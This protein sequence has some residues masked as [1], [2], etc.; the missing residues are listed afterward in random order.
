MTKKRIFYTCRNVTGSFSAGLVVNLKY[1]EHNASSVDFLTNL[2]TTKGKEHIE[3]I[4]GMKIDRQL[5]LFSDFYLNKAVNMKDWKEVYDSIDV[6]SLKDYDSLHI[7]GGLH[8]PQSGMTRHEKRANVFPNDRGQLKFKQ[9]GLHI[10]NVMAIHKAHVMYDIPLH[11]FSYDCDELSSGLFQVPQ[12]P[13]NYYNYHI[14]DMPQYNM[15]RLDCLQYY[16]MNKPLN[17]QL[18]EFED[19]S[20][21]FD[22]TFGYTVFDYGNRPNYCNYVDSM[23]EKFNSVNIFIKNSITG[24]DTSI[25]RFKY[26]DL[27]AKSKYTLILPSYDNDCFSLYRFVESVHLGCLPLIHTDCNISGVESTFN[28]NLSELVTDIPFTEKR[29]LD[30]I[31]YLRSKL[32]RVEKGFKGE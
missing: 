26:L 27:V 21:L 13:K 15:T 32:I 12:N 29:R 23:A 1:L 3:A 8:F 24:E 30:L 17:T 6:S 4:T 16:L 31:E 2:K 20:D 10:V 5:N 9:T 18:F 22:L 28:M 11:E 14:Y 25:D 19:S 7:V